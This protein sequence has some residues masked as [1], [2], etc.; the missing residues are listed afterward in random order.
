LRFLRDADISRGQIAEARARYE[1]VYTD[2]PG[3]TE[4][5]VYSNNYGAVTDYAYL[6]LLAG[7]NDRMRQFLLPA[8]DFLSER[9]RLGISGTGVDNVRALAM[10]GETDQAL[11]TLAS[12]VAAGWRFHWRMSLELG[13]LDFIRDDPRFIEQKE[14]LEADMAAQLKSYL[15]GQENE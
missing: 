7:E 6:L 5:I 1:N 3:R 15:S 2:F 10:L 4:L 11:E 8:L 12:A 13:S 14:I 9:P